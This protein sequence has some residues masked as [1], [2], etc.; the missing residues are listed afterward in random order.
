MEKYRIKQKGTFQ[1]HSIKFL[2]PLEINNLKSEFDYH[3]L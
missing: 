1:K 3:K 2:A